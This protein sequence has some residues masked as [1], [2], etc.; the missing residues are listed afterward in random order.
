MMRTVTIPTVGSDEPAIVHQAADRTVR[1][2]INNTGGTLV[3]LAHN[4]SD[5]TEN[6]VAPSETF[7]LRTNQMV[8][9]VLAPTQRIVAMAQ[10]AGG[11]ISIAVSEALVKEWLSS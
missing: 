2:V 5:F 9:V 10:G 6:N 4:T 3:F 8:V 7:Q 1:V 11:E